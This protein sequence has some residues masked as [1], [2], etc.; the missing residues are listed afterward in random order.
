LGLSF[1]LGA[2]NVKYRDITSIWDVVTQA[3]F[4]AVPVI[5][6]ISLIVDTSELAAK[7]ILINPIAQIIQDIRY[8]L[9]T[10]TTVTTWNFIHS[11]WICIIPIILV[12]TVLGL[13]AIY[14]RKKSR[15][16]A[17]EV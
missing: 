11:W 17:E 9:I 12:F 6:P 14:F 3:L 15:K 4:Y 2:I 13:A 5:Y 1:L 16:F 8:F 7:V 10:D